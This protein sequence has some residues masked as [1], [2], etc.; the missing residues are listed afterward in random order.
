MTT[1][2]SPSVHVDD[3]VDVTKVSFAEDAAFVHRVAG[4]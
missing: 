2:L 4:G 3:E 1:K